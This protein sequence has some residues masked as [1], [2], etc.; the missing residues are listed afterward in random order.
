MA[1]ES[2]FRHFAIE[3]KESH[4]IVTLPTGVGKT[5]LMG[6]LPYGLANGRVL[7]I[8]PQLV[9]KDHVADSLD[10]DFPG[11]FWLKYKVFE[12]M[13]Q[14]PALVEYD[15]TVSKEALYLANII[16]VNIQK[17]Q[18]RLV[19]SLINRVSPNHFDMIIVD[20]A[21][22]ST[23]T[24]W[25]EALNYFHNAKVVKLTGTP[26]RTDG[27]PIVG[28][29]VYQYR[30]S[31][32]MANGF[33]K[34]LEDFT[35]IPEKL[36][37]IIDG[38][39]YD[40]DEVFELGLRDRDWVSR[41]VAFSEECSRR[42]VVESV[43]ILKRKLAKSN[44][45]LKIIGVACSIEHALQIKELYEEVGIKTAIVHSDLPEEQK[46]TALADIENHRVQ[47]VVNVSM[48]GEGYDHKYLV[49][50]AIFRPFRSQLPYE[51]FI[52]RL[53]RIIPK[54]EQP[55]LEDNIAAIVSHRDL[56]LERL[57]EYYKR[58]IQEAEII[59]SLEDLDLDLDPDQGREHAGSLEVDLGLATEEG[60]GTVVSDP[61]LTTELIKRRRQEEAEDAKKVEE[62]QKL[63]DISSEEA[64]SV[65]R[66][67]KARSRLRRP[68]LFEKVRRESVD[69][70]IKQD[71]VPRLLADF[72]IPKES[73]SLVESRLFKGSN[74]YA[75]IT[76]QENCDNAA[77]LSIY[78]NTVLKERMG[79]K[80]EQWQTSDWDIALQRLDEIEE[81]IVMVLK[82]F[83]GSESN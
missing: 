65:L 68:D 38:K 8:T 44:L 57:W 43:E 83:T 35:Y 31:A 9:I 55:G 45:P 13:D 52:G 28:E 17:L 10:P 54:D 26:Y 4:A 47:A 56:Y 76:R 53:L 71:M 51:Q 36:V 24:T 20:E 19:S 66:Q 78:I 81:F 32:A 37:L 79:A 77:L 82:D 59:R 64:R 25:V 27:K 18:S 11:N 22:H 70:R 5:G 12:S 34:S 50:G 63:L 74:R 46:A 21:H 73:R 58:E 14:L 41:S 16:V 40:K 62:L 49:V 23:A 60:V 33:V 61:Y 7:I 75:W 1:Y 2:V 69:Q 48:L 80:R 67:T 3:Q 39:E 15:G 42:V 29:L 30:L 6:L 72:N